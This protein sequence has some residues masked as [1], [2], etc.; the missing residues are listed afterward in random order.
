MSFCRS[1]FLDLFPPLISHTYNC[2]LPQPHLPRPVLVD[3]GTVFLPDELEEEDVEHEDEHADG[4]PEDGGETT[5]LV[6]VT[7]QRDHVVLV[8]GS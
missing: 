4:E 2:S 6:A 7:M 8:G 3:R 1:R 5:E